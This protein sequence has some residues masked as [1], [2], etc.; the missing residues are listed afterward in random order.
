M[1]AWMHLKRFEWR[2]HYNASGSGRIPSSV[3][4]ALERHRQVAA[5]R[6]PQARI[7]LQLLQAPQRHPQLVPHAGRVRQ[8]LHTGKAG[9]HCMSA[10]TA[11]S[12]K[13]GTK[14]GSGSER[15][16]RLVLP[17]LAL[18]VAYDGV[19]LDGG[20]QLG[21]LE[22][23]A[24]QQQHLRGRGNARGSGWVADGATESSTGV[25][26]SLLQARANA[27]RWL[28]QLAWAGPA[29]AAILPALP[30]V[31]RPAQP[32]SC[33]SWPRPPRA[34]A[35]WRG[36]ASEPAPLP[37]TWS[38]RGRSRPGTP[39]KQQPITTTVGCCRKAPRPALPPPTLSQGHTSSAV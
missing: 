24:V 33:C 1:V 38:S 8:R 35:A 17:E 5:A 22:D 6:V 27:S 16:T 12:A 2:L 28:L 32:A 4:A 14:K 7:P 15:S 36:T 25:A 19:A 34:A 39:E 23:A 18:D 13:K 11:A 9:K 30:A 31:R 26:S 3:A 21:G 37:G 10:S 20:E 29:L